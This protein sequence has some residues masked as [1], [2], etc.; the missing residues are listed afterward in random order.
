MLTYWQLSFGFWGSH[1]FDH[2]FDLVPGWCSYWVGLLLEM[3]IKLAG[4][5][6]L[7]LTALVWFSVKRWLGN[8]AP[9]TG[10]TNCAEYT[11]NQRRKAILKS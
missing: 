9:W 6:I 7:S 8:L 1:I 10:P 11:W 5:I 4:N 3:G 2:W